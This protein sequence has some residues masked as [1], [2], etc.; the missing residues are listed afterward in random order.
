MGFGGGGSSQTRPHTHDSNIANDGGALQFNNVTQATM[1]AGDI[2]YSDGNHLQILNLGGA[3]QVLGV[4]GAAPAWITNTSNPLVKVS[5]TFADISSGEIDIYTLP[6]DAAL[7]NVYADITTVFDLSTGVTVGDAGDDNGFLEASDFTAGTGLTGATRG[8]YVQTF[9]TMRSTTGTTAIKAYNFSS[10][11]QTCYGQGVVADGNTSAGNAI[12][13]V[14]ATGAAPVGFNVAS[15]TFNMKT[16]DPAHSNLLY[17]TIWNSAGVLQDTSTNGINNNTLNSGSYT[18]M[19]FT[20]AGTHTLADGDRI[21]VFN[22]NG[23]GNLRQAQEG[24]FVGANP[25]MEEYQGGSW[26]GPN[27]AYQIEQCV[28]TTQSDSQGEVDF[29]LQVVD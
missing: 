27:T 15:C 22:T 19:V 12:S 23:S 18:Q 7:V 16:T 8:Q 5:K 6:Q 29:Y 10:G 2:T 17:A 20:F 25:A 21:A 4:S 3:G 13:N 26:N 9:K 14:Y 11:I 1:G 24:G 28:T